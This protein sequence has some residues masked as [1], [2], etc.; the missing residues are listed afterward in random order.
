MNRVTELLEDLLFFGPEEQH[1][2]ALSGY[3]FAIILHLLKAAPW[4][5]ITYCLFR[6]YLDVLSILA[7]RDA[8]EQVTDYIILS[9]TIWSLL[10]GPSHLCCRRG[11]LWVICPKYEAGAYFLHDA[12]L[13]LQQ[14]EDGVFCFQRQSVGFRC[15]RW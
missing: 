12:D 2:F 8:I 9:M 7:D 5:P 6:K 3:G 14:R 1:D 15:F 10:D 11:V 13:L 4:E